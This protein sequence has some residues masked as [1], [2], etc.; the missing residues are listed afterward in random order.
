MDQYT[1]K[2][3]KYFNNWSL[4][5]GDKIAKAKLEDLIKGYESDYYTY[6]NFKKS[7]L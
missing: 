4:K 7:K 3:L 5:L 2:L 1:E 6:T